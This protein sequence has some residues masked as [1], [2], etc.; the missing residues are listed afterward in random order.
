[1]LRS[2]NRKMT[3]ALDGNGDL[4]LMAQCV[5]V[6]RCMCNTMAAEREKTDT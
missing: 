3:T 2:L 4:T 5:S 6:N 1:M